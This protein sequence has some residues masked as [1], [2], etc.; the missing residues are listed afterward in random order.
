MEQKIWQV[1]FKYSVTPE[2]LSA[3]FKPLADP[4]A[5]VPGLLWKTWIIDFEENIAG[6]IHLFANQAALDAHLKSDLVA[7]ILSH[8]ALSDFEVKTFDILEEFS[9]F[10][11][12]RPE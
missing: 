7:G 3:A 11:S 1:T 2:E 4:I 10:M 9:R 5:Q 12:S 8:P 6:G